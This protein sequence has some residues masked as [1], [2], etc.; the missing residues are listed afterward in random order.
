MARR[1]ISRVTGDRLHP[2]DND[3]DG[4][5]AVP[6]GSR[7]WFAWLEEPEHHSFSYAGSSGTFTA[8]RERRHGRFYWYAYRT[9]DGALRKAYLGLTAALTP[10]RLASAALD[11]AEAQLPQAPL[12]A[13][14]EPIAGG[15]R[16]S[17]P[18]T[19]LGVS[20]VLATKLFVPR[21]R[22]DL[23]ARPRLLARLDAGLESTR[24]TL[25]SAPA[26]TGKT[27]LLA[28]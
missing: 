27:T 8:R 24:C 20:H 26:G 9:R 15:A 17:T 13:R 2:L 22:R 3:G 16:P 21:P 14:P 25:L 4:Q 23:V 12:T 11:L 1:R 6:V 19:A 7:A 5:P 18:T 10:E 28:V